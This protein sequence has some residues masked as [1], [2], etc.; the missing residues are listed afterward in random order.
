LIDDLY[1]KYSI[2]VAPEGHKHSRPGW[3]NIECPHCKKEG[4]YHLG[5]NLQ[6]A[7]FY[8]WRCGSHGIES[9]LMKLLHI[10]YTEAE[11]VTRTYKLKRKG[12][13]QV[14]SLSTSN[15]VKIKKEGFKFPSSIT[16]LEKPHRKYL[17]E[18][19]NFDPDL[20][21]KR[22]DI[23]G[24][25]PNSSLSITRE[26]NTIK[27]NYGYRILIPIEWD[28]KVVTFQA[29]DY[30]GKQQIKYMACPEEREAI[31]HKDILYGHRSLWAKRRGILVEGVFDV[32]RIG[33]N[34]C[35]TFGTG[36]TPE[37]VRVMIA[38][39]DELFILFDPEAIAQ[40]RARELQNELS[41]W[42][43]KAHIYDAGLS[44]DPGDMT[45]DQAR[46]ILK[47]LKML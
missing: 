42:G 1:H 5:F 20:L 12:V 31:H 11:S 29:R 8:C 40:K 33:R 21:V 41:F 36:Y 46:L 22:W 16:E 34:A 10:S 30:T 4:G 25:S 37:Q 15:L 17:E 35:C 26:G 9:T 2:P 23:K 32:W 13:V 27:I 7:Y 43:V 47:D 18:K 44:T 6:H 45:D 24:T 19:R 28:G 38:R 3:V 39:F 14:D